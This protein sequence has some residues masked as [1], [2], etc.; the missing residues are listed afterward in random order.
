MINLNLYRE[1]TTRRSVTLLDLPKVVKELKDLQIG[2]GCYKSLSTFDTSFG[3]SSSPLSCVSSS[4]EPGGGNHGNIVNPGFT[5]V[6]QE[7]RLTCWF[8]LWWLLYSIFISCVRRSGAW[9]FLRF[10]VFFTEIRSMIKRVSQKQLSGPADN[11]RAWRFT[12]W[13]RTPAGSWQ[14]QSL[15][16]TGR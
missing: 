14:M 3:S 15:D 16:L 4:L 6:L 13:S 8:C 11:K 10:L 1:I 7:G 5:T 9:R 2:T 12:W